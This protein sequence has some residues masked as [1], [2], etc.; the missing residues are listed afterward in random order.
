MRCIPDTSP[1][2]GHDSF[3]FDAATTWDGC[4]DAA[5]RATLSIALAPPARYAAIGAPQKCLA[6]EEGFAFAIVDGTSSVK[7]NSCPV[8]LRAIA[9]SKRCRESFGDAG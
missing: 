4:F 3:C 2:S 9:P 7:T 1:S 6:G 5:A 8:R